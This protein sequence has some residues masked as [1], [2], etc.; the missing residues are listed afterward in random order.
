MKK[1]KC[2]LPFICI[3][4]LLN[5]CLAFEKIYKEPSTENYEGSAKGP[6]LT[7][8]YLRYGK[9]F[10]FPYSYIQ[11]IFPLAYEKYNINFN[12]YNINDALKRVAERENKE[13]TDYIMRSMCIDELRIVLP[14]GEIIDLLDGKIDV[15]Y[16]YNG[17]EKEAGM[18]YKKEQNIKPQNIDGVKKLFFKGFQGGDGITLDFHTKIPAYFVNKVRLEYTLTIEWENR[19]IEK[20]RYVGIYN[21]KIDVFNMM[22]TT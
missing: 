2:L 13:Y 6:I 3:I 21:K 8:I 17:S 20:R 4:L 9:S 7:F 1:I 16:H 12:I 5:S 15:I 10:E 11:P 19:G 18:L 14:S 22:P